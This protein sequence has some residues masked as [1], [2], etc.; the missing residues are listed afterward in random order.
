MGTTIV[1]YGVVGLRCSKKGPQGR[2][3]LPMEQCMEN[4]LEDQVFWYKADI[5]PQFHMG[6]NDFWVL[7]Q[8]NEAARAASG[9]AMKIYKDRDV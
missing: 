6:V 2:I 9:M 8:Q 7:S 5:H 3:R 4:R 1:L